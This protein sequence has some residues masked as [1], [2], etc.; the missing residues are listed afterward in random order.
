MVDEH[1]LSRKTAKRN[2][3]SKTLFLVCNKIRWRSLSSLGFV[4]V[5]GFLSIL[6]KNIHLH[7][8]WWLDITSFHTQLSY[9]WSFL[10]TAK[11]SPLSV[12]HTNNKLLNTE[13]PST[14]RELNNQI[15]PLL[16]CASYPWPWY[17]KAEWGEERRRGKT[18]DWRRA[19]FTEPEEMLFLC[20]MNATIKNAGQGDMNAISSISSE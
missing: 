16:P 1:Q 15:S 17:L 8:L 7:F 12:G 19:A 9:F 13:E 20:I 3:S 6:P 2:Q 18:L 4:V 10:K 14:K 11:C 5:I